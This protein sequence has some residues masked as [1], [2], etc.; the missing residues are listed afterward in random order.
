MPD[1]SPELQ[2][3]RTPADLGWAVRQYRKN[4]RLTQDSVASLSNVS[5]GFL[6]DFE[7]GKPTSEIGKILNTLRSLGLDLYVMPR[8][9]RMPEALEPGK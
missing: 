3:I 7:N 6:S 1:K 8:G 2:Q 9:G 5:T 4:R